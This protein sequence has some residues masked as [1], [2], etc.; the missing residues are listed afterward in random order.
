MPQTI[1]YFRVPSAFV[2][3]VRA[4]L[5]GAAAL[6]DEIGFIRTSPDG[7]EAI[8]KLLISNANATAALALAGVS[9]LTQAAAIT[10]GI[11]W[12]T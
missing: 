2:A 6:P 3:A 9:E 5:E 12:D 7:T 4:F 11:S 1:C 8:V 10:L